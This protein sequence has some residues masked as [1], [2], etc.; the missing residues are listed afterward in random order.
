M[1]HGRGLHMSVKRSA[2]GFM[3][4]QHQS[5]NGSTLNAVMTGS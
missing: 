3:D 1:S 4:A 2:T 5:I